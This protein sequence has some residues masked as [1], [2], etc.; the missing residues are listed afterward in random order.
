[1]L[2]AGHVMYMPTGTPHAARTQ[3]T[4]SLHIT[5]GINQLTWRGLVT[6]AISALAA[7]VPDEH[8]P[9]GYLDDP[10]SLAHQLGRHLHDVADE[11]R[12][13]DPAVAVEDEVRRFL[14]QRPPRL[15]GGLTDVIDLGTL[16]DDTRLRRRPGHP[17]VLLDHGETVEV[18]LGDRS[19]TVPA[20]V[21]PAL[22]E[23]R[24]RGELTPAELP[25]DEQ[26]R[27]VLCR[28]LV[29]EGLLEVLP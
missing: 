9:A 11:L 6:R 25:L 4:I 13:V 2:E 29:R 23:I 26:S 17:C 12:G 28:R 1:M 14:T 5:I 24:A 3:D 18:L 10:Q 27:L 21:R 16:A 22:V 19:V 7:K 20:W 15:P 8:L